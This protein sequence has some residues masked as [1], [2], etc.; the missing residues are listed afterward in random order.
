MKGQQKVN[1]G[2]G[3]LNEDVDNKKSEEF[4]ISEGKSSKDEVA[5]LVSK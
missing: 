3:I 5:L 2:F 4:V 1:K